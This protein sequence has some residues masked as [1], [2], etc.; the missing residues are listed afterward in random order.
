MGVPDK[1]SGTSGKPITRGK[2]RNV[3]I[4]HFFLNDIFTDRLRSCLH[5]D[6]PWVIS[7]T[8]KAAINGPPSTVVLSTA[9][10]MK[11]QKGV[12]FPGR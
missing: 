8:T 1:R 2:I 12:R 5:P 4:S 9:Q 6:H 10:R 11:K 3:G 7:V